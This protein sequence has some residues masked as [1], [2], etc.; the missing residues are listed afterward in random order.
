[1]YFSSLSSQIIITTRITPRSNTLIDNIFRNSTDESLI[2][3]N[4]SY[5]ISDHL[6]Q[7]QIYPEFKAKNKIKN[8]IKRILQ[9]DLQ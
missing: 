1:M 8:K 9:K 7:F 5:S 3:G 2:S 6:A 4:L